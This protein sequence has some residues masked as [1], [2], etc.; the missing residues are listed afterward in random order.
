MHTG[1]RRLGF[2]AMS[3]AAH[4]CAAPLGTVQLE[5]P[6]GSTSIVLRTEGASIRA[7]RNDGS[8]W[9]LIVTP[10]GPRIVS[11]NPADPPVVCDAT[12]HVSL[13][14]DDTDGDGRIEPA[15]GERAR[16]LASAVWRTQDALRSAVFVI[17]LDGAGAATFAWMHDSREL[18]DMQR[19]VSAP[20]L[21]RN[22]SGEHH[23]DS[24]VVATGWPFVASAQVQ[25]GFVA[26]ALR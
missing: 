8:A 14:T 23:H 4:A 26:P 17:S 15:Q 5:S 6:G 20:T 25:A 3:F 1:I 12:L 9:S 10:E 11:S 18:P 2:F 7:Q 16:L 22:R 21:L 19:L 24:V 13:S